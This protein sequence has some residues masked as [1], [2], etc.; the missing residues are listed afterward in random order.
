MI[1]A[2]I[3]RL[4]KRLRLAPHPEGGYFLETYRAPLVLPRRALPRAYGGARAAATSILF[5]LPKGSVSRLHRIVSD[6]VWHFHLGE[7][8]LLVEIG[9]GGRPRRTILGPDPSAGHRLQ[10]VVRG[11][12]W[13]G[14]RPAAGAAFALVGCTVAPGFDFADFEMGD[15][16][17]LLRRFPAARAEILRLTTGR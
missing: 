1:D 10:H 16:A 8:L 13:F 12:T 2:E 14:A 4:V 17:V 11:G 3:Q 6:E 5:L 9:P 7:P 15:R